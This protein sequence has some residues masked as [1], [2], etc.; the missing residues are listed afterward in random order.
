MSAVLD[1]C[2]LLRWTTEDYQLPAVAGEDPLLSAVTWCEI[3]WKHRLGKLPLAPNYTGWQSQVDRLG[4]V[5]VPIDRDLFVA[6]VELDWS[7]RDPA[8]RLI[9]AL[10]QRERSWLITC[11]PVI[12][13]FYQ[14]CAW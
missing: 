13:E 14:R 6:A 10:A 12:R 1:T 8:D 9:G 2:A 4:L 7:H 5:T 3:A 11:D